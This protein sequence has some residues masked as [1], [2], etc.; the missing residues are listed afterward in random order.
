MAYS[1]VAMTAVGNDASQVGGKLSSAPVVQFDR[2]NN[3]TAYEAGDVISDDGAVAK[4]IEFPNVGKSGK[5]SAATIAMEEQKTANLELY[6]FDAEPTNFA[7]NA[8]LALTTDDLAK[9][10]AV[11]TCLDTDK[12]T[13]NMAGQ[14]FYKST[15]DAWSVMRARYAT[16]TGKLYGL[17]VTRSVFTP[18]ANT[19]YVVRLHVTGD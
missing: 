5:I 19:A 3:T 15:L 13:V 2:P 12:K 18:A 6:V 4:V 16:E 1:A 8:L 9:L 7:D 17:L 10:V 11:F 14:A